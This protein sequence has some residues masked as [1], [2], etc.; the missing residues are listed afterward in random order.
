M[1]L[2]DDNKLTF[3]EFNIG[4]KVVVT[5]SHYE[6]RQDFGFIKQFGYN[7]QDELILGVEIIKQ[8]N[9]QSFDEIHWF[10]PRSTVNSIQKI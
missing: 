2:I 5:R 7:H 10:H 3:A 1:A 6:G 9:T 4:D 8:F